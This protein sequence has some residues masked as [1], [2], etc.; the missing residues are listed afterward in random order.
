MISNIASVPD[1]LIFA[2]LLLVELWVFIKLNF[3]VDK[4]GILTLALHLVVS[5]IRIIRTYLLIN[6]QALIVV[7]GVTVWISL[8]YFIFEMQLIKITLT[9]DNHSIRGQK[10]KTIK[11]IKTFTIILLLID[12]ILYGIQN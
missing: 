1:I 2:S 11:R 12:M 5:I 7:A 4:S 9:S 6:I 10:R 3:K 8:Y